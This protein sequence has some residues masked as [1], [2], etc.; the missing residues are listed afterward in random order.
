MSFPTRE[1]EWA[2]HERVVKRMPVANT[3]VFK[4]FMSFMLRTLTTEMHCDA[5]EARD[6]ALRAVFDYL[7]DPERYDRQQSLLRSYLTH[8]AKMNVLDSRRSNQRRLLREQKYADVVELRARPPKE[9]M[10]AA[11]ETALALKRLERRNL[12]PS[13]LGMLRLVLQGE[14]STLELA[15]PLGMEAL[16]ETERKRVVKQ[17]RDRLF[18]QL[19]RLGKEED[20]HDES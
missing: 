1:E 6:C 7:T 4:L 12:K 16:P 19:R 20:S 5:E 17:N 3:E 15:R 18:K 10:E 14:S 9:V 11:V 8:A 2:L 13:D